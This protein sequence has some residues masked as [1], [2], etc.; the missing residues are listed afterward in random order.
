[1]VVTLTRVET[2]PTSRHLI[3]VVQSP[4]LF[5][6]VS[7]NGE[8]TFPRGPSIRSPTIVWNF[9]FSF[10]RPLTNRSCTVALL[11]FNNRTHL[12]SPLFF[13][14]LILLLLLV[15]GNVHPNP[16]P[17]AQQ[18]LNPHIPFFSVG[19]I[20]F[21][22]K[23]IFPVLGTLKFLATLSFKLIATSLAGA[24]PLLETTTVGSSHSDQLGPLHP[25]G[26]L[27]NITLSTLPQD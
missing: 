25:S 22:R 26:S 8:A 24:Q 15:S 4:L 16:G 17:V 27:P 10:S 18:P 6:V 9:R 1:M 19:T 23:L 14:P 21:I 12:C 7:R 13:S 2:A 3:V 20:S 11:I 5:R